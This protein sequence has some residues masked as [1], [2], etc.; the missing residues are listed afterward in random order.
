M[1][2]LICLLMLMVSVGARAAIV[3]SSNFSLHPQPSHTKFTTVTFQPLPNTTKW[4]RVAI[5]INNEYHDNIAVTVILYPNGHP[6]QHHVEV[7]DNTQTSSKVVMD[8]Y[9]IKHSKLKFKIYCENKT[10]NV[11]QSC[12]GFVKLKSI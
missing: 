7:Y 12:E 4:A 10:K 5:G 11:V 6:E 2:R 3:Q 8:L 1:K 9:D